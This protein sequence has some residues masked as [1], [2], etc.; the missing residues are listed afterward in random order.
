MPNNYEKM[1]PEQLRKIYDYN[2]KY[3]KDNYRNLVVKL[4]RRHDKDLI[5]FVESGSV[6]KSALIKQLLRDYITNKGTKE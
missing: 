3:S 4:D 5:Q 2:N 6:N 1:S